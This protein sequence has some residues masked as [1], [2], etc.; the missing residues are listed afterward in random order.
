LID[1]REKIEVI[2]IPHTH[3]HAYIYVDFDA[4]HEVTKLGVPLR[5]LIIT[6]LGMVM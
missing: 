2:N 4:I 1:T 6:F 3:T 5:A